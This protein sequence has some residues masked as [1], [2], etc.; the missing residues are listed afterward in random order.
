MFKI[1]QNFL[2]ILLCLMR[3]VAI[4]Q[5]PDGVVGT[6]SF[7]KLIANNY[8]AENA[9]A[10]DPAGINISAKIPISVHVV[11]NTEGLSGINKS[12]IYSSVSTANSVF[13]NA[14]IVFFID[15]FDYIGDYNY[16]FITNNYLKKEVLT[17]YSVK[18]SVNLFVVDSIILG[19]ARIYGFTYFPDQ[20]D[21]NQI[22]LDK[23]YAGGNSLTTLLG[24]FM[25]LLSTH[26]TTGGN[27]LVAGTNCAAS[28]DFIC[29][30]YADPN[31]YGLVD[32]SCRYQGTL[33]DL[34][35]K[36]Y[37]PS[38]ANFMSDAPDKCKCVFTP[39]QYRRIYYYCRNYR[40]YLI[41]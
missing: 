12:D 16:S 33:K 14:G 10:F 13:K 23:K 5:L 38:V 26:E 7:I 31:I 15:K 3:S 25:G 37:L 32:D 2:V 27:E 30:T 39:L 22:Y 20:P 36:Y 29:D 41:K 19:S 34:N 4:A 35:G 21:S 8:K 40:Q 6:E 17:L 1:K 24:H 11:M 18:N 9:L 28:G